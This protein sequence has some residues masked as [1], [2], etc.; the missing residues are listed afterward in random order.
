MM[1]N[2]ITGGRWSSWVKLAI[3]IYVGQA[4]LGLISGTIVGIKLGMELYGG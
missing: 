1:R 3:A 4:L 2:K